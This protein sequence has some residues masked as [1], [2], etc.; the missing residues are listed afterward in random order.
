[1][2]HQFTAAAGRALV[3]ASGWSNRTGC[4][5]LEVEPLLVGLLW[6][7]ECRA[8][9]M[10]AR[11]AIDLPAVRQRW[12]GLTQSD[13]PPQWGEKKHFSKEVELSLRLAQERLA[14]LPRPL[15]LAT[16]HILLGLA[17]ADHEVSLWLR[18]RG[19]D[20]DV[21]EAEIRKLYGYSVEG[22]A[23]RG[24]GDEGENAPGLRSRGAEYAAMLRVLD[25]A[26]NRA[27]EGLRVVEDYVRFVLDDRHLTELCKQLRHDLTKALGR[28]SMKDRLAAR[29]TQADVGT[30][31]TTAA[32]QS[33]TDAT[34]VL[35]ANFARL[36]ESLRS[37]EEF[38]K[39]L[40]A[41]WGGSCT[42][43]PGAAVQ[44]PPQQTTLAA[45]FKQMRYRTYTLQRAAEI[46]RDSIQRLAAVRLYVLIDGLRS[47]EEFE[48]LAR[49]LIEAGVH[50]IQLRDKQLGD[51]ELLERA[52]LLR[53]LI[54][55]IGPVESL[56]YDRPLLIVNDRPDLAALAGADG[57]QVGQ[58][59]LSVK[60]VRS[61]I[62][63]D[64]LLGVSI[65]S[66]EQA[67]Q[68]VLDGANYLGVGPTFAS[69]TKSFEEF[70]GVALLR[71][72]AAEI[73]L[74]AFAIGGIGRQNVEEVLAAGF[75]RIAVCGA[76]TAASNPT[77]AV[78]ELLK[79]LN[80]KTLNDELK[81]A[82]VASVYRLAFSVP[83]FP[84][85]RSILCRHTVRFQSRHP[86]DNRSKSRESRPGD[87]EGPSRGRVGRRRFLGRRRG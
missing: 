14:M 55:D 33:R 20:P 49:G 86:V 57:V 71:E 74:P 40:D 12:P 48:R 36:Q 70:P 30:V 83:A 2:W 61:I 19:L 76:V 38:G 13:P 56:P 3:Y 59:E 69:G 52:R 16:E 78:R 34:G 29:E 53:D 44:L 67:R 4:A 5:E 6:E 28:L 72:V 26:A 50:A 64:M 58:E 17:A 1:M 18:Q 77:E 8:A 27:R 66:I 85:F 82:S 75:T 25:A 37:L 42:A 22:D 80:D 60:D 10:L 7:P 45:I 15:E 46:T 51:R 35:T 39:L 68:A 73:R 54:Q 62:G 63:P 21:L 43:T 79:T 81:N 9:T 65:H 11:L 47:S 87:R 84:P 24:T 41:S 31:L 23:G 32:E